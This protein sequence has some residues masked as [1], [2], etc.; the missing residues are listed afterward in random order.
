[1]LALDSQVKSNPSTPHSGPETTRTRAEI[2]Q[3]SRSNCGYGNAK[4]AWPKSPDI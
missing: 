2:V 1:M 4:V 3:S